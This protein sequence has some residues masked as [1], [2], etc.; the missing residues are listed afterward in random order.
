MNKKIA[1]LIGATALLAM[2][3]SCNL[4]ANQG[5]FSAIGSSELTNNSINQSILG[6]SD[7]L[8]Y[9]RTQDGIYTYGNKNSTAAPLSLAVT[10]NGFA[11]SIGQASLN[12][13]FIYQEADNNYKV[14]DIA[15]KSA[16]ASPIT[17][18]N[19][20]AM[21]NGIVLT[22]TTGSYT[23]GQLTDSGTTN[24]HDVISAN[25]GAGILFGFTDNAMLTMVQEYR[26]TSNKVAYKYTYYWNGAPLTIADNAA[27]DF[28][29]LVPS[30][31]TDDPT[32]TG[33]TN[34]MRIQAYQAPT[35]SSQ[36]IAIAKI[37]ND[38]YSSYIFVQDTGS[39]TLTY[40]GKSAFTLNYNSTYSVP[41]KIVTIGSTQYMMLPYISGIILI[42]L[43]DSAS[44]K[45]SAI[46]AAQYTYASSSSTSFSKGL[47]SSNI[48][49]IEPVP[50]STTNFIVATVSSGIY[51][52]KLPGTIGSDTDR[53][54][55]NDGGYTVSF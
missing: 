39:T 54:S 4:D 2:L 35:A 40:L 21:N 19:V 14:Y 20:K 23:L 18:D 10:T 52:I 1:T 45:T 9:V 43:T 50:N 51:T 46:D 47:T 44:I 16:A 25:Q 41:S 27:G 24:T 55:R 15:T 5:I 33:S 28:K 38:N 30:M 34:F 48:I 36:G 6:F 32:T 12:N 29:K 53:G 22:G 17:L 13:K 7:N 31:F 37:A 8:V 49:D 26:N 3:L 42:D 11:S